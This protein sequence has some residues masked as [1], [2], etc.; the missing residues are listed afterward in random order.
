VK[1]AQLLAEFLPLI[2]S[3]RTVDVGALGRSAP[4]LSSKLLRSSTTYENSPARSFG[5]AQYRLEIGAALRAGETITIKDL[6][7]E[8]GDPPG[9]PSVNTELKLLEAAGLV[10]RLPKVRSDRRVF[11]RPIETPYWDTCRWFIQAVRE[12]SPH[13]PTRRDAG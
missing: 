5:G 6:A 7:S 12:G 1:P 3:S 13:Q 2:A 11:L 4:D 10:D 8:L 9:V